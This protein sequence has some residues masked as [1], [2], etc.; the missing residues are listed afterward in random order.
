MDEHPSCELEAGVGEPSGRAGAFRDTP[1][2][3]VDVGNRAFG[4][5]TGP[6]ASAELL[7][8]VEDRVVSG[9]EDLGRGELKSVPMSRDA[10]GTST[11]ACA[12]ARMAVL[13]YK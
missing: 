8:A 4:V 10:A 3:L 9:K 5:A 13:Y 1:F 6:P 11:S 2:C 12:T 7:R